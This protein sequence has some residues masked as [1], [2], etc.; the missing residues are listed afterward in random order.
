MPGTA[1]SG[2]QE[3]G[4]LRSVLA[5]AEV[6]PVGVD[7]LAE[8]GDLAH[9]VGRELLDLVDDVAQAP[10][11]LGPRT[12][13]T[14][15]KVH[16]LSQPIWIVTHARARSTLGAP[17][18]RR[19]PAPRAPGCGIVLLD[20]L[21]DR[22]PRPARRVEQRRAPDQVVGAEHDV[23]VTG[24]ARRSAPGP[25]GPG[26][27]RPRSAGPGGVLQRLEAAEVPVELVVGVLPDAARVEH[28]DVGVVDGV[29]R[30]EPVGHEHA[31]D[32]FGVVLV[33]L[34]AE[35]ADV[36]PTG[37]GLVTARLYGRTR[38]TAR[39]RPRIALWIAFHRCRS[40]AA[41][42]GSTERAS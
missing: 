42:F 22:V 24:R 41:S 25:S 20:D 15:Q 11:H 2:A 7:V 1:S 30:L 23:D 16:E 36:E 8:Q 40:S 10:A 14:M 12:L 39:L 21:D 37:V 13:G 19:S 18:A 29:G 5:R 26:S 32:A 6:A 35:G 9:A 17:A 33:H 3:V 31:R 28:D 27:R 38:S 34:A 4:E